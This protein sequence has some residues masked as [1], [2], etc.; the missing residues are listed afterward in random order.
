MKPRLLSL[1]PLLISVRNT[2]PA[3][4][5]AGFAWPTALILTSLCLSCSF[6]RRGKSQLRDTADRYAAQKFGLL[7]M[8]TV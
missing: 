2:E 6:A 8:V 1:P 3:Q 5:Q 7:R 4:W